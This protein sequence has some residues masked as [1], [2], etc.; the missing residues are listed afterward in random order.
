[1]SRRVRFPHQD[2]RQ[3]F[4]TIKR[5]EEQG[6]AVIYISHFLEEIREVA[7]EYVVLR[8]GHPA[9]AGRLTDT[10]DSQIVSLMA[11]RSIDQ[12]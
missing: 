11:G 2:V 10:S 5:L 4:A 1:M 12:L 3:L 9:G 8:D 7:S 6:L